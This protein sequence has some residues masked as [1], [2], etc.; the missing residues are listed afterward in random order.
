MKKILILLVLV[1]M[2]IPAYGAD[3]DTVYIADIE[4][5]VT[6]LLNGTN[7]TWTSA[8]IRSQINLA[9]REYATLIGISKEDTILTVN[10]QT[11]YAL[12]T[13]FWT[14]R[15]VLKLATGRKKMLRRKGIDDSSPANKGMGE[16][17]IDA[18]LI[19]YYAIKDGQTLIIDP[20]ETDAGTDTLI[21][22]YNV[23]ATNL[24]GADS[25]TNIRYG[26]IPV[27]VYGTVL[28]CMIR[29]REDAFVQV[30]LPIVQAKYQTVFNAVKAQ[31]TSS[32]DYD[33]KAKSQ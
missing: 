22:T 5:W 20:P 16:E 28:N 8:V 26:G 29:N 23:Y 33:P 31:E 32:F 12:N 4:T 10:S 18:N 21:V 27:I 15:G 3:A 14:V 17:D 7:A 19:Q 11:D 24:V 2:V 9:C 30:M 13:D 25:M 6:D 1:L